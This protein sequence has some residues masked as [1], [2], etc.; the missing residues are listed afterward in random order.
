MTFSAAVLA[1]SLASLCTPANSPDRY[2]VAFSGGLD[3][4]VLLHALCALDPPAEIVV[5]HVDH[6]LHD[7]S[8]AWAA[9]CETVAAAMGV[10]CESL[11]VNISADHD[12]GLEAA[13]REARYAALQARMQDGDWLLSAHHRDDQAETVLLNLLRG[14]GPAGMAGIGRLQRF[15]P[16]WLVR[17]LLDVA[18][19][20]L[21]A[22]AATHDLQWI[23]D[24]SNATTEFDRNYLRREVL[25]LLAG[26]W[27]GFAA[28]L[29]RSAGHAADAAGLL[30]DLAAIDMQ[31]LGSRGR[32]AHP[33]HLPIDGLRELPIERQRNVVRHALRELKLPLPT[34]AQLRQVLDR[35]VPARDD[36]APLVS[37]PGVAVRRYRNGLYLLPDEL[38]DLVH[39]DGVSGPRVDLGRGL[40]ALCFV[41]GA[42]SGLAPS[43]VEAGLSL[44]RR[45]GGEQLK[46]AGQQHT[47]K[48]KKLL[49]ESGVV[50]WMRDR[51]PLLYAGDKLVAVADLWLAAD[52][53]AE[54]GYSV[55]WEAR[56]ALH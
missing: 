44:R 25:P 32:A 7:D 1:Q 47:K 55:H 53:L 48:L 49:Q 15:S 2:L 26:R 19:E 35:A 24:P 33:G 42:E 14:T 3:S 54:P 23:D 45:I 21:Q 16:G 39:E 52:A 11:V 17:P 43:L 12:A 6:G 9:H 37:W 51:I 46:Y 20:S 41:K 8:A 5:L 22:Y 36:A 50:P 28:T 40:G 56:P 38:G 4:T 30:S 10:H 31:S 29:R 27:P 18:R 13:A 34:A